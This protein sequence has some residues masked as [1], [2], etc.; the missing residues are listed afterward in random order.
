MRKFFYF[1]LVSLCMGMTSCGSDSDDDGD[2]GKSSSPSNDKEVTDIGVNY[3]T[4]RTKPSLGAG[5]VDDQQVTQSINMLLMAAESFGIQVGNE[6]T[7]KSS[8]RLVATKT[9]EQDYITVSVDDL[10]PSSTYYYRTY[11]NMG[12]TFYYGEV[13]QFTTLDESSLKLSASA[14]PQLN[15]AEVTVTFQK[16]KNVSVGIAYSKNKSSLENTSGYQEQESDEPANGSVTITVN[17]IT[18]GE[19]VY[20][21]PYVILGGKTLWGDIV[22]CTPE[23]IFD[24]VEVKVEHREGGYAGTHVSVKSTLDK[25]Y[26]NKSIR[27]GFC[28]YPL[29]GDMIDGSLRYYEDTGCYEGGVIESNEAERE[30]LQN[31][32]EYSNLMYTKERYGSLDKEDQARLEE[33]E[34][35]LNQPVSKI[36]VDVYVEI[37][38]RKILLVNEL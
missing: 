38:G 23:N 14:T 8:D 33:L 22:N 1:L 37:S 24:Y 5:T 21:R 31:E 28:Y 30:Y 6:Q 2:G 32:K 15:G 10:A 4:I 17:N 25:K 13:H 34:A 26:P 18:G 12:G 35:L 36:P 11:I 27:F 29:H 9:I 19:T 16:A 7:L 20:L 3:A